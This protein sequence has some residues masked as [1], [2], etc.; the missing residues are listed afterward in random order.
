MADS[1]PVPPLP[2]RAIIAESWRLPRSD[3]QAL[4]R[5]IWPW[6]VTL[7]AARIGVVVATGMPE[8]F[9]FRQE[10]QSLLRDGGL[11]VGLFALPPLQTTLIR[12]TVSGPQQEVTLGRR[13]V[14]FF[15][16][17]SSA[18][19]LFFLPAAIALTILILINAPVNATA[20]ILPLL[21]LPM[22]PV[23]PRLMLAAAWAATGA[24]RFDLLGAWG[25][26]QG[27]GWRLVA[28]GL[29]TSGPLLLWMFGLLAWHGMMAYPDSAQTT[30]IKV[31]LEVT[32]SIPLA[33]VLSITL[34][35]I[36]RHRPRMA[37]PDPTAS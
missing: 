6:L 27:N 14:W 37:D 15:L 20:W 13:E 7:L 1:P 18:G 31:L 12:W 29:G 10:L 9:V 30:F 5:L 17:G 19:L 23:V 16:I 8:W 36:H 24:S 26:T 4:L 22:L 21:T 11:I 28:C 33:L 34:G 35:L 32:V 2:I 25:R 3:G